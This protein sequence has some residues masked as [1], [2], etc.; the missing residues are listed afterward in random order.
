ME[1]K[2]GSRSN[3]KTSLIALDQMF[4]VHLNV[5]WP[6]SCISMSFILN[7]IVALFYSQGDFPVCVNSWIA[8]KSRN[9]ERLDAADGSLSA[10]ILHI[11]FFNSMEF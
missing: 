9:Q 2:G 8:I 7:K 10:I 6:F 1:R 3:L 4:F 5:F 11:L